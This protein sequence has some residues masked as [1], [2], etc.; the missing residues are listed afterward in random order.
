[1]L[2]DRIE[3]KPCIMPGKDKEWRF[4]LAARSQVTG[5]IVRIMADNGQ[6]GYG[7]AQGV[8]HLG[9]DYH[10]VK[11]A[12]DTFVPLLVGRNP[13]A[14]DAR[15]GELDRALLDNHQA[16][17]GIEC[18][19]YD[20]KAR[21]LGVPV[22]EL[23]GGKVRDSVPQLR[24]LPIKTPAEM[25]VNAQRL[26]DQG[27]HYLKIKVHGHVAEDVERVRVIRKQV[28]PDIHL[29][30]DANQAYDPKS[31]IQAIRRM[32]EFGIDLV[33]QPVPIDD[34][35]GLEL[36]THAV[37]TVIEADESARSLTD[38]MTLASN[39][40]VDAISI[41]IPKLGGLRNARITADICST[42]G[43]KFRVGAAVGSRLLASACLH[44]AAAVPGIW[45]AC[46]LAQFEE[47]LEDPFEG[48]EVEN[49]EIHVSDAV[50]L[51][52][53]LRR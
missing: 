21:A 16:K 35:K 52:V 25:A 50:G 22:Y 4:A 45:Y 48:I 15:L 7:Y 41:K 34:F 13:F 36:V 38:V 30:I 20:L 2:I 28:G 1:M 11:A 6:E 18:A 17:A 10:A 42:T 8:P 43:V 44:F 5:W 46:E 9:A 53:Q 24:I 26:V 23:L 33:E 49:G 12:L 39:R 51:G 19:L 27:Y 3:I 14:I 29:T 37:E 31:A 32:E 47:L 40:M